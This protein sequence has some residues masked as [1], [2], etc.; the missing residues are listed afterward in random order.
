MITPIVEEVEQSFLDYSVSVITDR[1]IP[2]VEDGLKPVMRRILW[3][4]QDEG[5]TSNKQ[6]VK[7]ATPVGHT[8]ANYHPHGDSSIYGALVHASQSWSMRYPLIDFHGNNGSRDGDGPA[9]HRYTE[10]R[11]AKIAEATMEDIKKDTVD[12]VPTYAE[13]GVEPVYLPGKFPNL[14]CNGTTGIAVGMACSFAPHNLSEVMDAA[15]LALSKS[16]ATEDEILACITGPDFPTGGTIINKNELRDAYR[17]GKGRARIRGD[18]KIE[19]KSGKDV[20]VF[21]SIP[22]KVSKESLIVDIDALC[23]EKKIEGITE[24]R[25][26]SSK[27]EVRFVIDLA[28]GVNGDVIAN[29]LYRLTDLETTYSFNQVALVNK[30]PKL[31]SFKE[32]IQ[33]Y[34]NHQ[35]DVFER[36]TRYNLKK[37]E[38]RIHILKG[39]MIA[40]EDIDNIIQHIKSS[41]DAATAKIGLREKWNLSDAQADAI[42]NMKLSKLANVEKIAVQNELNEKTTEAEHLALILEN[43][44]MMIDELKDELIEFKNRFSD[45]RRTTV[46]QITM[47]E[48]EK[49]VAEIVPENCVV[50]ITE[51]GNIKRV[52]STSYRTQKRNG[53]GIK[54]Q[55][56]IIRNVIKTNT[57][58]NLMVFSTYGKVYKLAVNDI[59]VGTNTTRGTSIETLVS[60]DAGEKF[61]TLASVDRTATENQ[62]VWFVTK[63]GLIKKTSLTEYTGMK[64]KTGVI[65][66]NI[67]E[68]DALA[69]VF[70]APNAQL[71][72]FTKN[73]M[74]LRFDGRGVSPT[75]RTAVGVKGINLNEGDS[76]ADVVYLDTETHIMI[77][78]KNGMAKRVPVT[79]FILQ[80][81]A[82]KGLIC[83]KNG[84][85]VAAC[86]VNDDH[87]MLIVGDM[88]S[89]CISSSDVTVGSRATQGVM[90]IKGSNIVGIARIN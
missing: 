20:I 13:T 75:S 71:I 85:V 12:W 11:L 88:T 32:M 24:I 31:L 41:K 30:V 58:D 83:H 15:I 35:K 67:K 52:P 50:V 78:T 55:D 77:F 63:N 18:Y 53:K 72:L 66:I 86:P 57:I 14:M 5:L 29:K 38:D 69:K 26:E 25:D 16:N 84:E 89:I 49:E 27:G 87:M 10:C 82:G 8:M 81:R 80:N 19:T 22:Y 37:L 76:I 39:L 64:R 43:E 33:L 21:T 40:L 70:V 23:E 90:V 59:P 65:A 60:M 56:E 2:S 46:T 7:C 62:F 42:L 68:G 34:L 73:G 6:Y 4:M 74:S 47:T 9:A 1:A 3:D 45:A 48:E 61:V 51:A 17:T 54:N 28:K 79:D 36:K 44:E